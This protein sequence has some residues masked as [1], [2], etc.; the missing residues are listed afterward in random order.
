MLRCHFFFFFLTQYAVQ[1]VFGHFI[2]NNF[3]I[4][5]IRPSCRSIST[6]WKPLVS[7]SPH[8]HQVCFGTCL[9]SLWAETS[10]VHHR[11]LLKH[12]SQERIK[13]NPC[14]CV[15]SS[16]AHPFADGHSLFGQCF[17]IGHVVLHDGLEEFVLIFTV[18]RW[19]K[20]EKTKPV[21]KKRKQPHYYWCTNANSF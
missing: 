3:H 5:Y 4:L 11:S 18:K 1:I 7:P 2:R 16:C 9:H 20:D 21:T 10:E 17:R 13:R 8:F 15:N 19:L 14:R 12:F 6:D